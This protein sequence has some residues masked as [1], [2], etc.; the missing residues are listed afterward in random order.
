[1]RA[2][3]EGAAGL[4]LESIQAYISFMGQVGNDPSRRGP[5][6]AN[7]VVD[8]LRI[9]CQQ[10]GQCYLRDGTEVRIRP[11]EPDDVLACSTMLGVCSPKSLYS[12]YER[13]ITE[14]LDELAT[15]LCCPDF[16]TELAV[17]AEITVNATPSVIGVAQLLADPSHET[18]EYAVLVADPWQ[19]KGLG[20]AFTDC[21]LQLAYC[22]GVR[23]VVAE[24]L[25]D[26]VRIIHILNKRRFDLY[27]NMQEHVVSGQKIIPS[28]H[29]PDQAECNA[30]SGND[31]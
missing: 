17:V 11:V 13:V 29:A 10:N 4:D 7:Q 24:F 27:R 3:I 30:L 14:T 12:R 21:C 31:G 9:A 1:M 22:W 20:S 18:A 23:R 28:K 16:Q 6:Q 25:P 5:L 19:R 2:A 26:N 8:A 15:R